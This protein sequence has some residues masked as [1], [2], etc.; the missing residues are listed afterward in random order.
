M[1]SLE[2]LVG[3]SKWNEIISL[4][5]EKWNSAEPTGAECF[6]RS[7]AAF[8]LDDYFTAYTYGV[9]AFEMDG[10]SS[11]ISSYLASLCVLCGRVKESYFYRK[12]L[13]TQDEKDQFSGVIPEG[14]IPDYTDLLGKLEEYHLLQRGVRC[15][16]QQEWQEAEQWYQQYIAFEPGDMNGY[17]ALVR[18]QIS[19]ERF[20]AASESLK[21]AR[22]RFP[23][24]ETFAS[25]M[26]DVLTQLGQLNEAEA[27]YKWAIEKAPYDEKA[28]ARYIRGLIKNPAHSLDRCAKE[29]QVWI[30][31]HV[32]EIRGAMQPPELGERDFLRVGFVLK[33]VDRARIAPAIGGVLSWHDHDKFE[34][35]GYGDGDLSVPFNRYFKTAFGEWRDI[36]QT[37]AMTLRNMIIA[38]RVDVLI[39]MSGLISSET[40][41]LFGSRVA[42]IQV[43]WAENNLPGLLPKIDYVVSDRSSDLFADKLARVEGSSAFSACRDV[44]NPEET[45]NDERLTF[46]VDATFADLNVNTVSLWAKILLANPDSILLLRSHDFYAEDNS[47]ALIELFG[48]FGIAHRVDVT[49]TSDR[50]EFFAQGDIALLP[51]TGASGEVVLDALVAGVPVMA[52][53]Q[54]D[55]HT[56]KG[57]DVLVS[58]GLGEKYVFDTHDAL[59]EATVALARSDEQRIS[60]RE[61]IVKKLEA[62][63]FYDTE[64]RMAHIEEF[65]WG[66]WEKT[67]KQKA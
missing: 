54:E 44:I 9:Q 33:G 57:T 51:S 61:T 46:V 45:R 42:P 15:E 62:S 31:K 17:M 43:L 40:M 36:G 2:A 39:D 11:S 52:S 41:R 24:N 5:E 35:I 18:C 4:V 6:Y 58:L 1:S 22:A 59:V 26:G 20:R 34:F 14:L 49:Q 63:L 30:E 21:G 23:E 12:M 32:Q 64:K 27:C 67:C 60:F 37:D 55:I 47:R 7:L 13:S 8:A 19:Q 29:M 66:L 25:M 10:N 16:M 28:H 50:R 53:V 56:A 3:S 48:I 38:D 65:L